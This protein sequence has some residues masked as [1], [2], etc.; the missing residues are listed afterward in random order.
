[1]TS[2][3]VAEIVLFAC[4]AR[5]PA[6]WR[7]PFRYLA[8]GGGAALVRALATALPSSSASPPPAPHD[9]ALGAQLVDALWALDAQLDDAL[10][11]AKAAPAAAKDKASRIGM[12]FKV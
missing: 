11:D 12:E 9:T 4:V 6:R 2:G 10:A 5:L 8:L 7:T 3:I 1:M